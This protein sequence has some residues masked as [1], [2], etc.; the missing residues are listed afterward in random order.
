MT[1]TAAARIADSS[2]VGSRLAML[3]LAAS[4]LGALACSRVP[5]PVAG[6]AP[7]ATRTAAADSNAA[8]V[9]RLQDV[10]V[11]MRDGVVLR[12]D[13]WRPA[14]SGPFPVLVYR[15]PYDKGAATES[16]AIFGKAVARGYAVV[17]QDV[18]GR[19]ASGGEFRPYE[20]EGRDGYDT[21]EWAAR[22]PWS[23]GAVGT[24][25]LSYP[26]AVQWLAA[27]EGPP[28]LK[29]M[30]PA[31]T[32]ASPRQFFYAGGVWDN[33]WASWLWLNIA[34]DL[35]RRLRVA[36]PTTYED[37]EGAWPEVRE[38][39]AG[40]LP[41]DSLPDF[42]AIAPWYYEWLRH[43]PEDPWWEWAELRGRYARTTAAVLNLSGWHD[44]AYGPSGAVTNFSGLAEARR[45]GPLRA[46]L[47]VGPWP[48][49]VGGMTRT[50]VGEREVG[51]AARLD[52]DETVLRWMDHHVRGVANGVD[53]EP[54]VRVFVMGDNRWR[55]AER[56]PLPG[57]KADTLF[58]VGGAARGGAL[59]TVAPGVASLATSFLS[60]PARPV[61]DPYAER[62]GS[63]DYRALG[64]RDD[65]LTFES[66]PLERDL[67]VVGAVAAEVYLSADAPD[68]D[69][70][71]KLLD[72]APD[73]T[74]LSL[75]YPGADVLRAS[76]RD[77]AT[78][79]G[80]LEPGRARLLRL[81]GLF[82]G[83]TFKAGHRVRV[84][85]MTSFTPHFARNPQT[86]D[87]D[88]GSGRTRAARVTIH[89]DR[90]HPSR[91]ILPVISRPAARAADAR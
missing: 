23:N 9:V 29:A 30:A 44:E 13:V 8:A 66:A 63:H 43:P 70:W 17:I 36:G 32:F 45:A 72:V 12:A 68:T 53:R 42:R 89:H 81:P 40:V 2:A 46:R 18:R 56:W 50:T 34:P 16:Y 19:Y 57:T 14:S 20:Q 78:R 27:V 55:E 24:F 49:G 83:N 3:A 48:H 4:V 26:G 87:A 88:A 69:L 64:A 75:M 51:A 76:Y 41:P 90:L 91:L 37:A 71:V 47:I 58:L 82:T 85:L 28:H 38:R 33:S 86:G 65:V 7:R 84:Q 73:G 62:S 31:M 67:E 21:I 39:V 11:P 10:A 77:G 6:A 22:Q 54:P 74:A 59:D 25:G 60:D 52:Y 79:A 15:T 5:P 61:V 1:R 35:R 80:A